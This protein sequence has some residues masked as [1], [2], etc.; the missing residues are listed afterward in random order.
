VELTILPHVGIGPVRLSMPR[1]T[2][3]SVL[4]ELGGGSPL[5]KSER[6]D[7]FFRN[8]LQVEFETDETASF[9]EVCSDRRWK[10]VFEGIDVFDTPADDL[11]KHI[12]RF[13]RPD[14]ALSDQSSFVFPGLILTLWDADSQYDRKQDETRPI[15]G[16]VGIGD[17]RYLS[18]IKAIRANRQK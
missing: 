3:C 10:C 9:L 2:V 4:E 5:K 14:A 13:D 1:Q 18:A 17:E 11:L 7:C 8:S 6:T 15:F 16:A 12:Q